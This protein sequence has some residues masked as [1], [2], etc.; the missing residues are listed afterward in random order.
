M[1]VILT[2]YE[3]LPALYWIE[4]RML[5]A[6]LAANVGGGGRLGQIGR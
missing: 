5:D 3:I 6:L 2:A 4:C 1:Y